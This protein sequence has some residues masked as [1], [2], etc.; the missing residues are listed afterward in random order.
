MWR[1]IGRCII[2]I[3]ATL[4]I[5]LFA[6]V[7]VAELLIGS[8]V[9]NSSNT[10]QARFPGNRVEA[11]IAMVQCESCDM[12]DR[13]HAVWALGQLDDVRALPVLE[14]YWTGKPCDHQRNIC[15]ETLRVALRHLRHEDN[16]RYESLMWRW[17]L[18]SEHQ[19]R[20]APLI[21]R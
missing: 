11:L 21:S 10:A 16:N 19:A 1:K 12:H 4:V 2:G 3:L 18:P 17:M 6:V 14:K 15:Q 9:R 13:N 20:A 5:V 8:Q 7:S